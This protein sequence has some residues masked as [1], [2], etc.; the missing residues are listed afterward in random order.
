MGLYLL[1]AALTRTL[2]P[3]H[4]LLVALTL[5]VVA[6]AIVVSAAGA[7]LTSSLLVLTLAPWVTVVGYE[8]VGHRHNAE[9]LAS[10]PRL[11][12]RRRQRLVVAAE[13]V[14]SAPAQHRVTDE[15]RQVARL[16]PAVGLGLDEPD[17]RPAPRFE[18]RQRP[19]RRDG[20]GEDQGVL[21]RHAHSLGH[22]R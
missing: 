14:L 7:S 1:Y 4:F 2:D 22:V 20:L 21:D 17:P 5:V 10:L 8:L 6:A 9:V 3:F 15:R 19:A 11:L 16:V 12:G 18:V 13:D